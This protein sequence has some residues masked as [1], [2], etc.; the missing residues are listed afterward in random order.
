MGSDLFARDPNECCRLRKVVPLARALRGFSAWVSGLRRV[1]APSRANAPLIS[2]D[3][4]FHL[5]K[6]NP[7]AAWT[8]QDVQNY[9]AENNV[10]VNPLV[11]EGYLSIGCEPCT[12]R[13]AVGADPRSGRW[14]G[15]SK[16]EC[17]LHLS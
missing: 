14:Q 3:E 10:W 5:V 2:F 12:A 11:D 16:T 8:D 9:I 15:R 6:V 4:V 17:G 7:L 13:P 1:E